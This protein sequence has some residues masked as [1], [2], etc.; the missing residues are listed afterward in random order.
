MIDREKFINALQSRACNV[1][2]AAPGRLNN[3]P[4][5]IMTPITDDGSWTLSMTLR[6]KELNDHGGEMCFPGGKPDPKDHNLSDTALRETKEEIGLTGGVVLGRL[7][8]IPLYT[9][10]FRLEPFVGMYPPQPL[11]V[12]NAEVEQ[13]LLFSLNDLL[14]L[15]FF[16]FLLGLLD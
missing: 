7:S 9:S 6:K 15:I 3:R 1:W 12:S 4:A 2:P 5:A 13:C 11:K 16:L 10:D 14:L 8:S